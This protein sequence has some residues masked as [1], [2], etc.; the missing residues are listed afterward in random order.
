[1]FGWWRQMFISK[2]GKI[3]KRRQDYKYCIDCR[4]IFDFWKYDHDLWEAGHNGHRIR[5][6]TDREFR[7]AIKECE[8]EGCFA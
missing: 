2:T 5:E 6:L 7:E 1:M 4:T 8:K 3:I